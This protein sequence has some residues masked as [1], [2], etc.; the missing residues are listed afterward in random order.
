MNFESQGSTGSRIAGSSFFLRLMAP[1]GRVYS[2]AF[3]FILVSN[4]IDLVWVR[5]A[6]ITVEEVAMTTSRSAL[7]LAAPLLLLGLLVF[8]CRW[9]S[10][11]LVFYAARRIERILRTR[12]F[13]AAL[14]LT[15]EEMD[16][17]RTG[18]I[19]SRI[20]SN[21][22]D[23]RLVVGTGFL[24][25]VNNLVAYAATITLMFSLVPGLAVT[26]LIPFLPL[27][28]ATK[29]L[30]ALSHRRSKEAQEA[31]GA[32]SST[33]EETI[34]GIEVVKAYTA[35]AWQSA[36]FASVNDAHCRSEQRRVW[37]EA[38]F[39]AVMGSVVW[40]GVAAILFAGAWIVEGGRRILSISD[41]TTFIFLFAKLVW[42]TIA[43]GWIMNVVQR[44]LAAA[45]RILPYY[46]SGSRAGD[47]APETA[48]IVGTT[49]LSV[50][51]GNTARGEIVLSEVSYQYP[52]RDEESLMDT[53]LEVSP[54]QWIAIVGPTASGKTT[55][56]RL[57]AGLRPPT[58]G[59]VRIDG[60]EISTAPLDVR[61]RL[62]H[63]ATQV[64]T[65]FSMSVRE[66]LAL[67]GDV[68]NE[69][70]VNRM[71]ADVDFLDDL[72]GM[73]DA[74][75]TRIGERGLLFSGGQ[76]QRLSLAR[77]LLAD[78]AVLVLDD[79]ISSVDFETE[80]LVLAGIMR[81]R[82]NK[83]TIFITHRLTLLSKVD[84]IIVV[85]DGRISADGSMDAACRDSSWLRATIESE[86]M[87]YRD[88]GIVQEARS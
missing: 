31:L 14:D 23:I 84:R 26:A 79:V 85:E 69:P 4:A 5:T 45:D 62:V 33:V 18:D 72:A 40:I 15:Q 58:E 1:H 39:A 38:L 82:R 28:V 34:G 64:P 52:T 7:S 67:A 57:I 2:I 80:L 47:P 11:N 19:V 13:S 83:T 48:A 30:T 24:Q 6:A 70:D 87:R 77:G 37:P 88:K 78:P 66:N 22:A 73:P 20:I 42:P 36:R 56:A 43:L 12:V 59:S 86:R 29:Y 27:L 16:F 35:E 71:L 46:A 68:S 53:K 17:R 61:R 51:N 41:L 32:L 8:L 50:S 49:N 55:L 21:V 3:L 63:L 44:G 54:G 65:L 9:I 75:E 25:I 10:R 76:R 74:L 60:T 81:R